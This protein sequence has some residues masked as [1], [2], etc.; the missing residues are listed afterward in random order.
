MTIDGMHRPARYYAT[1]QGAKPVLVEIE[2]EGPG[3]FRVVLNGQLY[4]VDAVAVENGPLSMLVG[5]QH[6][7]VDF[8]AHGDEIAVSLRNERL[9]VDIADEQR[10]RLRAGTRSI[11]VQG[12]QVVTAP[13]P[14][15]V[16]KVLVQIGQ[17]VEE[18]QGLVVIEA[19]KMEN[20]LKSPKA[21]KVVEL[22]AAEGSVVEKNAKLAA[23]D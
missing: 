16:V 20:E 1:A 15:K 23:V 13:M 2:P 22:P 14:G 6:H 3:K 18:G 17:Q 7:C 8:E 11:L 9:T 10:F 12:R 21:G 5:H 4:R 19:M